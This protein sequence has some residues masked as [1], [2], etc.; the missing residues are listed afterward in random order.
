MGIEAKFVFQQGGPPRRIDGMN[1]VE[2]LV[3]SQLYDNSLVV[4]IFWIESPCCLEKCAI[5]GYITLPKTDRV[6]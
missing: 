3:S 2:M 5:T 6:S 1:R 4:T